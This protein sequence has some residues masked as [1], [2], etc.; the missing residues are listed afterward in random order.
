MVLSHCFRLL[1]SV[2]VITT[3]TG[4][5]LYNATH[6]DHAW[7]KRFFELSLGVLLLVHI[8]RVTSFITEQERIVVS[9]KRPRLFA[10]LSDPR[11]QPLWLSVPGEISNSEGRSRAALEAPY[12]YEGLNKNLQVCTEHSR[13]NHNRRI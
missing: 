2:S 13:E 7:P 4:Y 9:W 6:V 10:R 5:A 3:N 8:R 1:F 12:K 11:Q